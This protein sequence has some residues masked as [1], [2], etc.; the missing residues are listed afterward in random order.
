MNKF[1]VLFVLIFSAWMIDAALSVHA[2]EVTAEPITPTVEIITATPAPTAEA[3]VEPTPVPV[4]VPDPG[5]SNNVLFLIV[6]VVAGLV[7]TLVLK[8]RTAHEAIVQLGASAPEWAWQ[9]TKATTMSG[10]DALQKEAKKTIDTYDD[11]EVARLRKIAVDT[12]NEIDAKRAVVAS[13]VVG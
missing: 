11:D 9:G 1:R 6:I 4:P 5:V 7:A 8:E 12:I 10:L 2:Q 3:T 13:G